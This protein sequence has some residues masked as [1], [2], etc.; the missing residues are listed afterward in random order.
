MQ[1]DF[2]GK[3]FTGKKIK[4]FTADDQHRALWLRQMLLLFGSEKPS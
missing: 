4:I 1:V 2:A 3:S